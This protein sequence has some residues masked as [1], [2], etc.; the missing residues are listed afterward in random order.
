MTQINS[1]KETVDENLVRHMILTSILSVKKRFSGE[2]G[3][4]VLCCDNKNFWRKEIYPY[5][6]ASRKKSREDSGYDWNLIFN[7]I[8]EVKNDLREHFPY[9]ILEIAHA[10]ADD[11]IG[12]LT[13][14]FSP[15]EKILII[16]SDKDFKQLQRYNGVTQYSPI[17]KKFIETSEPYKY[18]R[19]HTIRGD[20]GDGI[21]NFLSPDDVFVTGKRQKSISKNNIDEWLD[22]DRRPE[23]FCDANM[24]KNYRRN[25]Q[26]VDLTFI[27]E[28]I[29][30]KIL[31]EHQK[32]PIGNMKKVFDYFIKNKMILL[33]DEL[34]EFKEASYEISI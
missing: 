33:M 6:K 4:I 31:Q 29:E 19:E 20:R 18:I 34:S 26:L 21:P 8:T 17:L 5:Y 24:L 32:L 10:E 27:P 2:Y 11:I 12:V 9:K 13:R 1:Y 25:E 7:T 3:N 23:D 22:L 16:S 14:H 28:E 15:R 30:N